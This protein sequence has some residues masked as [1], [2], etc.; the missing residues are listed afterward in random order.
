MLDTFFRRNT[1]AKETAVY[2]AEVL[3]A[4]C[5]N[6]LSVQ[7]NERELIQNIVDS[8][9]D[10]LG[11]KACLMALV[12]EQEN[13]RILR[14]VAYRFSS[15]LSTVFGESLGNR[16]QG[17]IIVVGERIAGAK[18][19]GGYVKVNDETSKTNLAV[20][21]IINKLS[22]QKTDHLGDLFAPAVT[23]E[24]AKTL[25]N[26]AG[27]KMIATVPLFDRRG[28]L[29]GNMY[30]G[31]DQPDIKDEQISD[32]EYF[33]LAASVAINNVHQV[34]E[35]MRMGLLAASIGD[36][37][38]RFKNLLGGV[39]YDLN[40]LL[41]NPQE[42]A[43]YKSQLLS[44]AI[45]QV[46]SAKLLFNNLNA[47]I[48]DRQIEF[49]DVNLELSSA[50]HTLS[51]FDEYGYLKPVGIRVTESYEAGT[52][53]VNASQALL[54]EAFRIIMKNACEAMGETGELTVKTRVDRESGLPKVFI[55]IAD[56]GS[57]IPQ[58]ILD[59][60]FKIKQ[61]SP[62]KKGSLGYGLW[63][64]NL[65]IKWFGGEILCHSVTRE[66]NAGA[67]GTTFTIIL[68]VTE[69]SDTRQQV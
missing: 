51:E 12:Q 56:T 68:P 37:A 1:A 34:R 18:L 52:V 7:L 50:V 5:A 55:T 25:Q 8:V 62:H 66:Q 59:G 31:T 63:S 30:A 58:K 17:N 69:V 57:G 53:L 19:M 45:S 9:V 47:S 16:I 54:R 27:I 6:L 15:I 22:S 36:V 48:N 65:R 32:L 2:R 41:D 61:P 40:E 20:R 38:H 33:A 60:L 44:Q 21:T 4:T 35:T 64:A 24:M 29:V 39:S 13:E 26:L 23:R 67:S 42:S 10:N 11:F 46:E 3:A 14:I 43:E 28:E 49:V